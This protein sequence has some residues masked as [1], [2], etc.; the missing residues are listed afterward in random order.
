MRVA[1]RRGVDYETARQLGL[2]LPGVEEGPCYGTPALRVKGKLMLRL[3]EDG[4]TVVLIVGFERRSLLMEKDPAT[5]FITDHYRNYPSVL[6]RLPRIS[7]KELAGLI[8]EAWRR[9]APKRLVQE[10]DAKPRAR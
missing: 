5:F 1:K 6:V 9:A 4:E 2:A 10:L 3:K 8:E 7:R